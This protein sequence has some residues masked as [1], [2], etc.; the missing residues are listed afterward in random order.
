VPTQKKAMGAEKFFKYAS[1]LVLFI[2]LD[3]WHFR[4][5]CF[6]PARG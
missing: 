1:G 3:T 6:T 5:N 4:V 2:A